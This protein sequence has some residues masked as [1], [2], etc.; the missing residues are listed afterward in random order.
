MLVA[1]LGHVEDKVGQVKGKLDDLKRLQMEMAHPLNRD[2]LTKRLEASST[3]G[4]NLLTIQRM[5]LPS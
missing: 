1:K 3:A 2:L 5:S 4:E